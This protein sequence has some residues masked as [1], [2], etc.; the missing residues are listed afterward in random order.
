MKERQFI[1]IESPRYFSLGDEAAFFRILQALPL[2]KSVHGSGTELHIGVNQ[3]RVSRHS[4]HE[5]VA[6]FRRYGIALKPLEIFATP[7]RSWFRDP[8]SAWHQELFGSKTQT[9]PRTTP[10]RRQTVRP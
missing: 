10:N 7:R 9:R 2:T 6:L 8:N 5:M 3:R 1:V 4:V